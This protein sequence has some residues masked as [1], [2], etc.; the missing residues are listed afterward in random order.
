MTNEHSQPQ[1][2]EDYRGKGLRGVKLPGAD[3]TRTSLHL[4]DLSGADLTGAKVDAEALKHPT[5]SRNRADLDVAGSPGT[6]PPT[7]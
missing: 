6:P 2:G 4:A 7:H 3:L 1:P 5:I